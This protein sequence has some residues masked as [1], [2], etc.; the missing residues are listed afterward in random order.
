MP[1]SLATA[2]WPK[3][4]LAKSLAVFFGALAVGV[5]MPVLLHPSGV[6]QD[7]QAIIK[8]SAQ[9]GSHSPRGAMADISQVDGPG[10]K[11]D[12]GKVFAVSAN[13][14]QKS[15]VG[16]QTKHFKVWL[17]NSQGKY[18]GDPVDW[19]PLWP[20]KAHEKE[21]LPFTVVRSYLQPNWHL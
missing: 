5:I 13:G 14:T 21:T 17:K 7:V 11:W 8:V 19:N 1:S 4:F 10:G 6:P 20:D 16:G 12:S 9:F 2:C 3:Q 15:L 18:E